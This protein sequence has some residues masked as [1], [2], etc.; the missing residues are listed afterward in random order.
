MFLTEVNTADLFLRTQ[1][2]VLNHLLQQLSDALRITQHSAEK[3]GIGVLG[4]TGSG[5]SYTLNTLLKATVVDAAEYQFLRE[6][7]TLCNRLVPMSR[8]TAWLAGS[9]PTSDAGPV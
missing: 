6:V 4:T 5:K 9:E 3:R 8:F 1:D 2:G 7:R